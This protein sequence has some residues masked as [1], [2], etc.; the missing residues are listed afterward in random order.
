MCIHLYKI[1]RWDA[2]KEMDLHKNPIT[3]HIRWRSCVNR[4]WS[5]L[6]EMKT[7]WG[8]NPQEA[9][10]N[11]RQRV[12]C[13]PCLENG[14]PVC[15]QRDRIYRLFPVWHVVLVKS[16]TQPNQNLDICKFSFDTEILRE[17]KTELTRQI[18]RK[19]FLLCGVEF[20]LL[21]RLQIRLSNLR[22]SCWF[23][24]YRLLVVD[25]HGRS[26]AEVPSC[27]NVHGDSSHCDIIQF[28]QRFASWWVLT[29]VEDIWT[30]LSYL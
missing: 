22:D 18:Q 8:R 20:D 19:L 25:W 11:Q 13:T 5:N 24:W 9:T 16:L 14:R 6:L 3:I 29:T 28:Q 21:E 17:S 26:Y 2:C 12:V 1:Q 30:S 10:E 7:D 15:F 27:I 23:W 4:R